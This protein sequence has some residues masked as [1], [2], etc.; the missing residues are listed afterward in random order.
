M[1]TK[2]KLSWLRI[3]TISLLAV[4][5]FYSTVQHP[6][7]ILA[8]ADL[9]RAPLLDIHTV[10][11]DQ[12]PDTTSTFSWNMALNT[13]IPNVT[14]GGY[15]R[16]EGI[17]Y[18]TSSNEFGSVGFKLGRT[19]LVIELNDPS[20]A[21]AYT[22]SDF[23]NVHGTVTSG[24][25]DEIA[26]LSLP[27]TPTIGSSYTVTFDLSN[28]SVIAAKL[29]DGLNPE[30]TLGE[31]VMP[32]SFSSLVSGSLYTTLVGYAEGETSCSAITNTF[33]ANLQIALD[34][35][36][37]ALAP[38][39]ESTSICGS[40]M[41]NSS[42][43][44]GTKT[45]TLDQLA[46]SSPGVAVPG[47]FQFFNDEKTLFLTSFDTHSG[48]EIFKDIF[49]GSTST[50]SSVYTVH[51]S[52]G[53]NGF[54]PGQSVP[55]TKANY[56]F[57]SD[58]D[59]VAGSV[60]FGSDKTGGKAFAHNLAPLTKDGKFDLYV[61]VVDGK[62]RVGVCPGASSLSEVSETC[63]N[64]YYL[65]EGESKTHSSHSII[66]EGATVSASK[67][68]ILG[69]S[70]W[71]ISGLTGS[72]ALG[73]TAPGAPDTGVMSIVRNSYILSGAPAIIVLAVLFLLRRVKRQ[74]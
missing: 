43:D 30:I 57:S 42:Y 20:H 39:P 56:D 16:T 4:T 62:T 25:T 71:K 3:V 24:G 68:T 54:T 2:I 5:I 51:V 63:T 60:S 19:E 70:Y 31:F 22:G 67:E 69:V 17:R 13:T 61:P 1:H 15:I 32:S 35:S 52:D 53:S 41:D 73:A 18:A 8:T 59:Y 48:S 46:T 14:N 50:T 33:S 47:T 74:L 36:T 64:L 11:N 58:V 66:P 38:D 49:S 34:G 21:G 12:Y 40:T 55:I 9:D 26:T 45:A 65:S 29:I 27:L 6:E 72:G 10:P 37:I 7:A 23:S 44:S 28:P